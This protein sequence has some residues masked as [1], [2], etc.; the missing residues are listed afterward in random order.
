MKL[1]I[2]LCTWEVY[3]TDGHGSTHGAP[4]TSNH[5]PD[6][7]GSPGLRL[8]MQASWAIGTTPRPGTLPHGFDSE[9][10]GVTQDADSSTH[11]LRAEDRP[12]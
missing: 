3:R 4:P 1:R 6:P 5:P 2:I 8:Y 9:V 10:P 7:L 11:G 12:R